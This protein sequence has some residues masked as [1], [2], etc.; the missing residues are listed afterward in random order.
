MTKFSS[1]LIANRG[2]IA[3]RVIRT[4]KAQGYRTVAVY[5]EADAGAPHVKMADEAIFIGP[6]PVN[7]S[8]LVQ[9]KII[10]AARTSGAQAVH[11]GYGFLSENADFACA[12]EAAGLIFIGPSPDAIRLMGNKAEAKR[13]MLDAKVPCVPGYEGADQSDRAL[14]AEGEKISAPLMVKA[15]AGGGGRGMRLV[16]DMAELVNAIKLARAEAESAFGNGELILEKAIVRPRHVEV[17]VFADTQGN[18]IHLGERDCSVQRRHQKV[19]EEAPCPV[20]TDTLRAEMGAAAVAAAKSIH[21]RGAGTVEFLLDEKGTFYFLEMNT[22]LQV[23]HPVTEL[24]TGLDLVALQLQVAQ[25]EPLGLN[26][27]DITLTGHAIEARLYTEDP[28]QDF[29]PSSGSVDLWSPASGVG[30]RIDSGICTGQEI[31]PFYDP[32]VAKVIAHGPTRD[33][34]R[35]RL[36]EALNAT[37]LFGSTHNSDFLVACLEKRCFAEGQAT[38]AFIAEEFAEGETSSPEPDFTDSAVA[39][40]LQ[41]SLEYEELYDRAVIVAPQLR[42]WA[43]ASPLISRKK[44]THSEVTTHDLSVTPL[45]DKLY[46]VFN[47][48]NEVS[49]ELISMDGTTAHISIDDMQ[50]TVRYMTPRVGK[51]Y[52]SMNGRAN[53]YEDQIRLDGQQNEVGG[54]GKVVAPMHGLLLEIRVSAGDKVASGQT[55]AVLEAM[56]MHYE[57]VADASGTVTEVLVESNNQVAAD[58][59]LIDIDTEA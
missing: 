20:M 8:Y 42:N 13:R 6:S 29:L 41:L 56:K 38:T 54:S 43:S 33:I 44:Y 7:E 2:E 10:E 17:Q 59:L 55:L 30:V 16:N 1:I 14:I 22:R 26:Q 52:L 21:Y 49:V 53:V 45:G 19:V 50:H 27:E 11:P 36:I 47:A 28:A 24:I 25:G 4:A 51:I 15:A 32:M 12:C 35:L 3:C 46:K 40:A 34:A 9:E 31:S 18:T 37:V 23:E 5:S 48:D 57:I 58:D 39:A